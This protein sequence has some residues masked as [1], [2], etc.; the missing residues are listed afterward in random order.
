MR[1]SIPLLLLIGCLVISACSEKTNVPK[2]PK[3]DHLVE[4]ITATNVQIS[5]ERE[6][7]G[8]LQALQEIQIFNQEEGRIIDLPF[9][10]GDVIKKGDIVARMD[11]RLLQSQLA[12]TQALRKKAEKDLTRMRNIANKRLMAEA[13]MTRAETDLAVAR[14]DEQ[15]LNTRLDYA[16]LISPIN[17]LVSQRLS[18]AGNVAER[19][20][21]LLTISDQS[22]LI[23]EVSV[24]E[25]LINKL[26][27]G[28]AVTMYIDALAQTQQK[29]VKGT[30]TRIHPNLDPVTRNGIVEIV[31]NPVPRG[32]RPGQL[33]RVM[34]R[35]QKAERLLIPFAAL[36]RSSEG[37]YVFYVDD[38]QKAS[39]A[40][41]V[42]GLRVGSQ[43]EILSGLAVGQQVVVRGFT[44]LRPNK[45]VAVVSSNSVISVGT[46]EQ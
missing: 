45:K 42:S 22:Q 44:N 23:T 7:T 43:V 26:N 1:Q 33:A 39:I 9:Y 4:V 8:T 46:V 2:K 17:G 5:I 19:Y 31:L 40:K 25:L 38:E 13:E 14:A 10:E 21:H 27:T 15:A 36:R 35:S 18:E 37:E 11:V 3:P 41:V 12:R 32:A 16:T 6:R 34:L 24:S 29:G 28:D 20:S 30:I